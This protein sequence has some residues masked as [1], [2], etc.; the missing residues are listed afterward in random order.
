MLEKDYKISLLKKFLPILINCPYTRAIFLAGSTA[1][2]N[3]KPESDIDLIIISQEKRVWLNRLFLELATFIFGKKRSGKKIK[4]RFCFNIFLANASPLL[5]HQDLIGASFYKNIKPVWG[6][7]I[8]IKKFWSENFWLKNFYENDFENEK[9]FLIKY[10]NKKIWLKNILEKVLE[11][12]RLGNI[13][14]KVSYQ[15]QTYYLKKIFEKKVF[16]KNS[17]KYDFEIT[18]DLIAYHFPISNHFKA[19]LGLS[20]KKENSTSVEN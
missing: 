1:V 18:P 13:L 12:I 4:N 5:P 20:T 8:E 14:E 19:S 7:E 3:P 16:N 9:S 2:G 6:S 15:T 11:K 10:D 17:K